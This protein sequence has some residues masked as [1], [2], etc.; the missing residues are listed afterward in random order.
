MGVEQIHANVM[1]NPDLGSEFV[2]APSS[3]APRDWAVCA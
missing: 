2:G 3:M 1:D